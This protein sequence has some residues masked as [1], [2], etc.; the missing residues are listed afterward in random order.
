MT[1]TAYWGPPSASEDWCEVN[2]VY[3]PYIAEFF[4]VISSIPIVLAGILGVWIGLRG[5]Y[6]KRFIVPCAL[7]ILVGLGSIAFHGTL[8][9]WGQAMDELFVSFVVIDFVTTV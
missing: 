2:Y 8:L 6:R 7:T 9:Y 5:G 1:Y 4:N 3:S